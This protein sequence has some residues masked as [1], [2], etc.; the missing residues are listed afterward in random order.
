M[1]L[2]IVYC[3]LRSFQTHAAS[4]LYPACLRHQGFHPHPYRW[5]IQP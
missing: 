3:M 4:I 1:I 5:G 2:Y